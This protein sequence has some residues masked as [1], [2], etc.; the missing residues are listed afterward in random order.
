[1]KTIAIAAPVRPPLR[2]LR[3]NLKENATCSTD[4]AVA[5]GAPNEDI[6]TEQSSGMRIN[7]R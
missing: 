6:T 2:R 5:Q 7:I 4:H 1:M 3:R